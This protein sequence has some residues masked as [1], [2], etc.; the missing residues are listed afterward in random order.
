MISCKHKPVLLFP[1][2]CIAGRMSRHGN[3][4]KT[5]W[6]GLDLI[7]FTQRAKASVQRIQLIAGRRI[8]RL[9]YI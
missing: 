9:C 6:A 4:R 1:E 3:H 2:H 5:V 7:T 8:N